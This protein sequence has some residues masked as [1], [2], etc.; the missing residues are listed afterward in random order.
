MTFVAQFP[1]PNGGTGYA[2]L[3]PLN[4]IAAVVTQY[5]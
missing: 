1:H 5:D 3:D 4:L 2:F